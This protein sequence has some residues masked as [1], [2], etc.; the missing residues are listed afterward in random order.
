LRGPGRTAATAS[1][2]AIRVLHRPPT[3]SATS[4][5]LVV[6]ALID[7]CSWACPRTGLY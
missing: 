3:L 7:V 5:A 6:L 1:E 2:A 4:A